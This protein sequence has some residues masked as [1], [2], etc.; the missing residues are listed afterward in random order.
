MTPI[1]LFRSDEDTA[2]ERAHAGQ[3]SL[4]VVSYRSRIPPNSLVIG[5]Y[6]VLPF[7]EELE[8]EL[9][10]QGSRLVNTFDEH[11]WIANATSWA[12]PGALLSGM[13]PCAFTAWHDLP[14]GAYIVKGRTNS[15]KHQWATH[16]FA[17]TRADVPKVAERLLDDPMIRDQG[18]VVRPYV[19][20][21]KLGEGV[22]G[23]PI[24]NEFRTFWLRSRP[25]NHVV[26]LGA[27]FYWKGSHPE[28]A[29]QARF[30]MDGLH[31]AE[32]AAGRI[33]RHGAAF[34]TVDVAQ[35]A[36]GPWIVIEV[37]DGQMS[38]LC[39]IDPAW[40]YRRLA[41]EAHVLTA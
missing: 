16:M 13:T 14:E 9:A 31:C 11:R 21:R 7:Y 37:N 19:P 6:S 36:A 4:P 18:L 30:G 5:R 41:R 26:Y 1:L 15:R 40:F 12:A 24:V 20:L 35:T 32:R 8:A 22:N 25:E 2:E 28:L 39:G 33:A 23:L 17:P 10:L 38:G 29:D 3:A 34:F 27:G